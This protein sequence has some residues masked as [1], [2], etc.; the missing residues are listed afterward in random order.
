MLKAAPAL[1]SVVALL[2]AAL[3]PGFFDL[4]PHFP[5][6]MACLAL[7][8]LTTLQNFTFKKLFYPVFFFFSFF[9]WS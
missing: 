7:S 8:V 3:A 6:I 4:N 9:I 5:F 1:G 2:R